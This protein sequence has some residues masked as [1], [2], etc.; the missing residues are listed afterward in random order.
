MEANN[1]NGAAAAHGPAPGTEGVTS[2]QA[3]GNAR[4]AYG[5]GSIFIRNG[6]YFGK[7]RSGGRQ[8]KRK[9]GQV[10][11]PG[12]RDG[13]TK[14]QAEAK[15]R[16]LM[17][18]VSSAPVS[19]RLT[20]EE[21]GTRYLHH[22]EVVEE[23]KRTTIQDY[24][25]I[26]R[27]HLEPAFRARPLERV[28]ADDVA[29]YIRA[30]LDAGYARQSV[31]NQ[32]NLLHG[33]YAF[34][35]ERRWT[36][37]NPAAGVRRPR[38]KGADAD[39]RFLTVEELEA[40]LRSVPDDVLGPTDHALYVS[41]ALLGLRESELLA[42]RWRDVD[43]AGGVVRV[44]RAYTRGRFETPKSRL[45]IRAAP[46]A[47]RVATEFERHFKRSAYQADD[48]LVLCHPQTGRPYDP[49]R[50]LK[51]FYAAMRAV[52]MGH[53]VGRKNGITFHSFRHTYGTH[54]AAAGAPLRSIMEWMGHRDFATTLIYAAYAGDAANGRAW[55]ERAFAAA[56]TNPGTNLSATQDNSENLK[57]AWEV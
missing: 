31:I 2:M 57:P 26:L 19:E 27:R 50:I 34:A 22:L 51:R 17:A 3:K 15:L 55:V 32:V 37:E 35:V 53:R 48:D 8:V 40:L 43:W 47:D 36:T 29:A 49:S 42:L 5:S 52:G 25:I 30:K 1:I 9:L 39:I 10:R 28:S 23:R 21:A 13:L 12:T 24:R 20:V 14:A 7:W 16:A 18:E 33:I 4:R 41:A 38:Q 45:S 11:K 46:M 56:G 6:A 44:R 54:M